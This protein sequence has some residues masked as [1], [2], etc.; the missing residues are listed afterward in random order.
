M[1]K[2]SSL[3]LAFGFTIAGTLQPLPANAIPI[4]A[5]VNDL[6]IEVIQSGQP[7]KPNE[8]PSGQ[9]NDQNRT[10]QWDADFYHLEV[11]AK[12]NAGRKLTVAVFDTGI[13]RHQVWTL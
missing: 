8:S 1:T 12:K 5:V 9:F 4:P 6:P 2:M 11:L 13:E 7:P 3:L 10:Q